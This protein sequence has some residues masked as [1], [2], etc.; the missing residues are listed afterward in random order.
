VARGGLGYGAARCVSIRRVVERE[1]DSAT[2]MEAPET[3]AGIEG[4]AVPADAPEGRD[5]W[6]RFALIF[7]ALAVLSEVVYYGFALDSDLFQ[8]YLAVLA[9]VSGFILT[10]LTEGIVVR[11]TI[12][13]GDLF[14]VQIAQ[15][16]DAY[17]ICALLCSAM[18]AYPAP[19]TLKAWGVVCGL[20][21]LN[22]LNLVRICG[23]Y[24]IG[25]HFH[26]H[27]QQSHEVYFPIFLIA[28]TVLAWILWVRRATRASFGSA[29]DPA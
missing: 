20:A 23:L 17:R 8:R 6:I 5:P 14:S 1:S 11:G 4:A 2:E 29:P 22:A 16:C 3:G 26:E 18:I 28:M 24:F 13:S 27:F 19:L 7:A 25:G 9:R 21:W 15:G 10:Q 12:I